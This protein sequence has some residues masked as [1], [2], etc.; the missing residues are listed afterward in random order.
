MKNTITDLLTGLELQE[1]KITI[2]W[3]EQDIEVKGYL[4]MDKKREMIN[5]VISQSRRGKAGNLSVIDL[6]KKW[7]IAI[8]NYYT[9]FKFDI[10]NKDYYNEVYD[11]LNT[12]N[13]FDLIVTSIP[14]KE[15]SFISEKF[16]EEVDK[17]N[18]YQ[19]TIAANIEKMFGS[20]KES[21]S[22]SEEAFRRLEEFDISKF[23]QVKTLAEKMGMNNVVPMT[24]I[25]K[26]DK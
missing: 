13:F 5:W 12:N 23:E 18:E 14:A 10:I 4:S 7:D 6:E 25:E 19:M 26:K 11:I 9:N 17:D 2:N 16:K 1:E 3:N 24:T 15:Y 8:V 21:I 20:L 22:Q